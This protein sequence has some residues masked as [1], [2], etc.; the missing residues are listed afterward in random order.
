MWSDFS[1][2]ANGCP[3]TLKLD[4]NELNARNLLLVQK[5]FQTL[6]SLFNETLF[7]NT[8]ILTEG[9]LAFEGFAR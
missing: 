1:F 3:A 5:L 7:K 8:V 4:I 9:Q 2:C 6:A